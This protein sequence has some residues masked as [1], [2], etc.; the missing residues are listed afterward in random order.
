MSTIW[1]KQCRCRAPATQGAPRVWTE[2]DPE[3]GGLRVRSEVVMAPSCDH[4]GT[5][6]KRVEEEEE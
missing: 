1:Q 4:C 5:P 3:T 6:W 2:R